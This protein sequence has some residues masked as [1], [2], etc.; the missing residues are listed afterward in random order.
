MKQLKRTALGVAAAVV[1][2]AVPALGQQTSGPNG[3]NANGPITLLY[4]YVAE[5]TPM[6]VTVNG[7]SVDHLKTAAYDDI[8]TSVHAGAN[9]LTISWNGPVQRIHVKIA[10]APTRNN[11]TNVVEYA[12]SAAKDGSLKGAG[13]KTLTFTIPG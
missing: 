3:T 10:Y 11:F 4:N 7:R 13:A 1:A 6:R 2:L 9:T 12:A 8:T 5:T